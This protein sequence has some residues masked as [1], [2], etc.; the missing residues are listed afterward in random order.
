MVEPMRNADFR[1]LTIVMGIHA[2]STGLV[3]LGIVYLK[4]DFTIT[5]SHLAAL[6]I[7]SS[8]GTV[9]SSFIW[10]YL[11]DRIGGR[12]FGAAMFFVMPLPALAWFF[13]RTAAWILSASST[14]S[15]GLVG[16]LP[17]SSICCPHSGASGYI[18]TTFRNRSGY[19]SFSSFLS[20]AI[21]GG[22]GLCQLNMLGSLSPTKSRTMAMA[23]H[24]TVVGAIGSLGV[25]IA[26]MSWTTSLRTR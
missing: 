23:V 17:E 9:L 25:F 13:V 20:G 5:Y 16:R 21:F 4:K 15:R 6:S 12:A 2:F 1:R 19:F 8:I 3:S 11:M 26:A 7:A 24:W 10:G 22:V 14:A 18:R